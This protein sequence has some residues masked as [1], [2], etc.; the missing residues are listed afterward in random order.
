MPISRKYSP[1]VAPVL[2]NGITGT[3]GH[4]SSV[5]RVMT[6]MIAGVSGDG[7]LGL[8]GL[9]GL[10]IFTR[11]DAAID[12]RRRA[13]RQRVLRVTRRQHRRHARR[14]QDGVVERNRG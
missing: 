2:M 14:P 7:G 13:L 10:R 11:Q 4:I 12:V 5:T 6:C 3:P 1:S 8:A 9:Y